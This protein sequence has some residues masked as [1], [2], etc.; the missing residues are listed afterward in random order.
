MAP[1]A[2]EGSCTKVSAPLST[3]L[4][5]V[6]DEPLLR[7][8]Q[9]EGW[10]RITAMDSELIRYMIRN[11]A[12]RA[13]AVVSQEDV[14]KANASPQDV[15]DAEFSSATAFVGATDVVRSSHPPV[16]GSPAGTVTFNVP[17]RGAVPALSGIALAAVTAGARKYAVVLTVQTAEPDNP[18]YAA[19]E[20]S[21][22]DG[23]QVLPAT[24][25]N[26]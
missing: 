24:P 19:D 7:L 10:Q 1:L 9:P 15:I 3:I 8:P 14:T 18:D 20:K 26:S 13:S 12:L 2:G 4:P 11:P 25:G 16:C 6:D 23:F 17:E 5:R 21:I 22:I